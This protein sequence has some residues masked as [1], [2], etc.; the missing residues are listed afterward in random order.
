VGKWETRR[1]AADHGWRARPGHKIFVADRGAVRFDVPRSWVVDVESNG[2][3]VFHDRKPPQDDCRLQMTLMRLPATGVD[4]G[5]LPLIKLFYESVM[6]N[7]DDLTWRTEPLVE[8]RDDLELVWNEVRYVDKGERREAC[9]R[10]CLAR[11]DNLVPLLTMDYWL[12]DAHRFEPAWDE[13][14]RS[15]TLGVYVTDVN[16]PR[17]H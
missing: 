12:A 7:R 4:W 17:L 2:T 5:E 11:R 16:G 13:V 1:L 10:T 14:V 3:V 9:S 6:R 15:L 8:R